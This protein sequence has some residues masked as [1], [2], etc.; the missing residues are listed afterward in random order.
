MTQIILLAFVLANLVLVSRAQADVC[1][2]PG[3]AQNDPSGSR[4]LRRLKQLTASPCSPAVND[5]GDP[6]IP[7]EVGVGRIELYGSDLLFWTGKTT[8]QAWASFLRGDAPAFTPL[9]VYRTNGKPISRDAERVWDFTIEN[10]NG[11]KV[12]YA[13]TMNPHDGRSIAQFDYDN[14]SRRTYAYHMKAGRW[15]QDAKPLLFDPEVYGWLGHNYGHHVIR[16]E[17]GQAWMFYERVSQIINGGPGKTELFARKMISASRLD[18]KEIAIFRIPQPAYPAVVRWSD[19]TLAEG[20]RPFRVRVGA[21]NFYLVAFSS[22][23]W[24]SDHYGINLLW[25]EKIDGPYHPYLTDNNSDLKDFGTEIRA[26]YGLTYGPGRPNFFQ[27]PDGR[28]WLLFH[29]AT[30]P[31]PNSVAPTY[32]NFFLAPAR[33]RNL[34]PDGS[35]MVEINEDESLLKSEV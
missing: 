13:G 7:Y 2:I 5:F 22:S 1:N 17:K 30:K 29:A 3:I 15:T 31:E 32:R 12:L 20:P 14:W 26:H 6:S 25:S 35:P 27:D 23:Q 9:Q 16:D 19:N 8:A 11:E 34:N 33:I 4:P 18:D 24:S 21:K 10:I 28:W